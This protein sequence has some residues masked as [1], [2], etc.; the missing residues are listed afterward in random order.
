[1]SDPTETRILTAARV[2]MI[3]LQ[4]RPGLRFIRNERPEGLH[5]NVR[6]RPRKIQPVGLGAIQVVGVEREIQI[7]CFFPICT[8]SIS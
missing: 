2:P 7:S 5:Q 3:G 1:M 6:R 8:L 4:N